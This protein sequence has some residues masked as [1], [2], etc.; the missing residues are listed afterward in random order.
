MST[1]PTRE[2]TPAQHALAEHLR[3]VSSGQIDEWIELYAADGIVEFPFAPAGVPTR[4]QG[5]EALIAHMR[6]FPQTFDVKF[7]DVKFIETTDPRTAV[8]EYRSEGTTISTGKPYEQ[9]VITVIH[10][11]EEGLVERF[12]DYWNPLVVIE[13]MT[14]DETA[15]GQDVSW[16]SKR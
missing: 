14:P 10:L 7:V 5:H 1:S 6:G 4:V 3:L 2:L 13:S 9:T 8:A 12:V 15:S 11:D 16:P